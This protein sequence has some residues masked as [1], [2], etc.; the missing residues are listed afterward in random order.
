MPILYQNPTG[1]A[2]QAVSGIRHNAHA[3]LFGY[4]FYRM[5]FLR[6]L[7]MRLT[8]VSSSRAILQAYMPRRI[9]P[10]YGSLES[11]KTAWK[12]FCFAQVIPYIPAAPPA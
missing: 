2:N 6:R 10:E 12:F 11:G 7:S 4:G 1:F 8:L 3:F 9:L 5:A